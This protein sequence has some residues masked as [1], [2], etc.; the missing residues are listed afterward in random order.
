MFG[1][2]IFIIIAVILALTLTASCGAETGD[3][4]AEEQTQTPEAPP[5]AEPSDET[6]AVRIGFITQEYDGDN[7][8]EIPYFEYDGA[9]NPELDSIN[10]SFNQGL[11]MMYEDFM[12]DRDEEVEWIEIRS[13]PF[14]SE[15]CLQVVVTW[16]NYPT[17]GTD[18]H[19]ESVNYDIKNNKWLTLADTLAGLG[20]SEPDKLLSEVSSHFKPDSPGQSVGAADAT[21]FLIREDGTV[22]LLLEITVVPSDTDYAAGADSWKCFYLFTPKSGEL[23]ALGGRT[24]FDPSEPDQMD[25]PLSYQK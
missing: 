3:S 10:R 18:G 1:R 23:R 24:L 7:I 2:K 12:A 25:P 4:G 14:T 5:S 13:Y 16:C 20:L 6:S 8:A 22:D 21:G 15:N 17:Y 19:M 9:Q 11:Q